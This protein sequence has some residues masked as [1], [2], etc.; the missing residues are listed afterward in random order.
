[1]RKG[2]LVLLCVALLTGLSVA[3]AN[4][5]D[6][7]FRECQADRVWSQEADTLP[8][9]WAIL[10]PTATY[11]RALAALTLT[12]RWDAAANEI[13][14][15]FRL[16]AEHA[17]LAPERRERL[18]SELAA[19][20]RDLAAR[21][22][23]STGLQ[24]V[25][26]FGSDVDQEAVEF[27]FGGANTLL[28]VTAQEPLETIRAVC[29]TAIPANSLLSFANRNA[30]FTVLQGLDRA[31]AAW[32]A[33]NTTGYAQYPWELLLNRPK[34]GI[35]P[36][37]WQFVV[38]HPSVG[39]EVAGVRDLST[40]RRDN[41]IL[42]EPLGVLWYTGSR[43][44]YVGASALISL[45]SSESPAVG[46]MLHMGSF[47]K[48]GFALRGSVEGES[49]GDAVVMTAD[50]LQLLTSAPAIYQKSRDQAASMLSAAITN[51]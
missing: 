41:T 40:A 22:G 12:G 9:P 7:I 36:P 44:F 26:R 18:E 16:L 50:L 10:H 49:R 23:G 48:I 35:M 15:S 43:R 38:M 6:L 29:W 24:N 27:T 21:G 14:T 47:V 37:R 2:S 45:P 33:F 30:R 39:L 28:R 1:M 5:Q 20:Q 51:R 13:I 19:L 32:D 11:E 8:H 25:G 17:D 34:G 42:M 31:V 46:A 3:R 4:A